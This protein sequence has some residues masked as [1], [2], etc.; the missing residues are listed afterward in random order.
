MRAEQ[1]RRAATAAKDDP[2]DPADY[3]G[4]PIETL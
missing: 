2:C 3:Y 1:R 4:H